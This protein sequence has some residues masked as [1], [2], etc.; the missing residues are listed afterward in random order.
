MNLSVDTDP[1]LWSAAQSQSWIEMKVK[2]I[3]E[4]FA[5]DIVQLFPESGVELLSLSE[6]DFIMRLPMVSVKFILFT[7]RLTIT[8]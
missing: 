7:Y 3:D 2:Q 1:E 8:V 6:Q 4:S 5:E